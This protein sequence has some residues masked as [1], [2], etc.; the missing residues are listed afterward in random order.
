L[1]NINQKLRESVGLDDDKEAELL[2]K[3]AETEAAQQKVFT[4]AKAKGI[5]PQLVDEAN[6]NYRKAHA[7]YDLDTQVKKSTAGMRPNVGNASSAAK[8]PEFV[9]PSKL[10]SRVNNLY[11]SGRLQEAVG[12]QGANNLLE[13][14]NN[15]LVRHKQILRNVNAVKTVGKAVGIGSA[16]AAGAKVTHIFD[17]EAGLLPTQ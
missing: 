7:L 16:L 14:A 6:Q 15:N 10:F 5:D 8:N 3:K 4:A 2:A 9:D 12:E 13:H 1:Q 17:P 11:D